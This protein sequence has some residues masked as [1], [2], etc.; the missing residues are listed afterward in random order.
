[1]E[2][3]QKIEAGGSKTHSIS[4]TG[5]VG[6]SIPSKKLV[7]S[8]SSASD[9]SSDS[10]FELIVTGSSG[11]IDGTSDSLKKDECH[12]AGHTD[13]EFEFI[14]SDDIET[15]PPRA[16]LPRAA[17]R[18]SRSLSR[19]SSS[20]SESSLHDHVIELPKPGKYKDTNAMEPHSNKTLRGPEPGETSH[21]ESRKNLQTCSS[22]SSSSSSESESERKIK[23]QKGGDTAGNLLVKNSSS[24]SKEKDN[25]LV[26]D[27]SDDDIPISSMTCNGQS[28]VTPTHRI[29]S[30]SGSETPTQYPPTQ[31]MERADDPTS[32][33][34]RIPSRVFSRTKSTAPMEWS[35]ASNESLFSIQMGNM[36]FTREQLCWLGKSG[37]LCRPGESALDVSQHLAMKPSDCGLKNSRPDGDIAATE[38]RAA[39]TMR[40]V[41][42]EN[43]ENQ[44]KESSTLTESS[45]QSASISHQSDG[46]TKSFQF[47]ILTGEGG[48]SISFKGADPEKGKPQSPHPSSN[49][50]TP[51]ES[52]SDGSPKAATNVGPKRWFSC[53]SCCP[54]CS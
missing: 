35:V 51:K 52:S 23:L 12:V 3:G 10:S 42:R 11:F 39:E 47:P 54:F 37:E 6:L 20:A 30:S 31:V 22:T 29:D 17:K 24:P 7:S 34:Y 46:S 49:P 14:S 50:Q 40:E 15:H 32:P 28:A 19:S 45:S 44:R 53:F 1:M 18:S 41:I 9:S 48:K 25:R 5:E 38:A 21:V 43:C 16:D 26:A 36:S 33:A 8:L 4:S 27:L 2:S 13:S